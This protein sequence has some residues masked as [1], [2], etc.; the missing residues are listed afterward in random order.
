MEGLWMGP[1]LRPYVSPSSFKK[2]ETNPAP[3]PSPGTE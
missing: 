1:R 2:Q 3:T